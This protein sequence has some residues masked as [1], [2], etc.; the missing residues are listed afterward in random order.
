ML[1]AP[2]V[3][4]YAT[5]ADRKMAFLKGTIIGALNSSVRGM[6]R[7]TREVAPPNMFLRA[8]RFMIFVCVPRD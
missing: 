2:I 4:A 3:T 1:C 5:A 6:S 7:L 8:E